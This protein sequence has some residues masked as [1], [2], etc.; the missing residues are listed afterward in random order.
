MSD[1]GKITELITAVDEAKKPFSELA[2]EN[3]SLSDSI[4]K[5]KASLGGLYTQLAAVN[6]FIKAQ[7]SLKSINGELKTAQERTKN[8][9]K[10]M[11]KGG[12][13]P[14]REQT[15]QLHQNEKR[16]D[17]LKQQRGNVQNTIN[18]YR[19]GPARTDANSV[20]AKLQQSQ[21]QNGISDNK[22]LLKKQKT[23]KY[24]QIH[25]SLS[26]AKDKV[27]VVS[28]ASM[29]FAKSG[30]NI[31]KNFLMHGYEKSQE[32]EK[33]AEPE[34]QND[35]HQD[36]AVDI[37]ML[38]CVSSLQKREVGNHQVNEIL[39]ITTIANEDFNPDFLKLRSQPG[40]DCNAHAAP[41]SKALQSIK[42]S[43][44]HLPA[45]N[46]VMNNTQ[47]AASGNAASQGD[48]F[49]S[50]LQALQQ[51][52]DDLSVDIFKQQEPSLRALVQTATGYL[53]QLREWVLNNQ[54]L[55]QTF[56]TI[57]IV[58]TGVAGAIGYIGSAIGPVISGIGMVMKIASLL[59]PVFQ[60][61]AIVI[62]AL[63]WPVAAVVV[64]IA[65]IAGVALLIRKYWE[66]LSDFFNNIFTT[67][68][69]FFNSMVEKLKSISQGFSNLVTPVKS[70]QDIIDILRDSGAQLGLIFSEAITKVINKFQKLKEKFN[71]MLEFL[72]LKAKDP[73]SPDIS[74][75]DEKNPAE[76]YIPTISAFTNINGYKP[77]APQQNRT[78]TDQSTQNM[79][80]NLTTESGHAEDVTSSIRNEFERINREKY[81]NY[82]SSLAM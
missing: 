43:C 52:Y 60:G 15:K 48:N 68:Q 8:L 7:A 71:T 56:G 12:T 59:G 45:P 81:T 40:C 14:T 67:L 77:I 74:A 35:T 39:A 58:A 75:T 57:A 28:S 65:A 64:A 38:Q 2:K 10:E 82:L 16:I 34:K 73:V 36:N 29:N 61:V 55:V 13:P 50:D 80:I 5:T 19:N 62:G 66:P 22:S 32:R 25:Q 20:D 30:F 26:A 54:G 46:T 78:I 49:G 27:A 76:T 51:A 37:K 42:C 63:S 33:A 21:L 23:E 79:V 24:Q 69:S 72:H 18:Q 9:T 31:G 1:S 44:Q 4:K 3:D 6:G 11:H 41:A 47:T 53:G 17:R 70:A